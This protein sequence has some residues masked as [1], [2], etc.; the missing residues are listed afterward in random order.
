MHLQF[1][2]EY[3]SCRLLAHHLPID[4]YYLV[5]S[6]APIKLLVG[7]FAVLNEIM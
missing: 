6:I 5:I 1:D 4:L 3:Y 2:L 7:Q